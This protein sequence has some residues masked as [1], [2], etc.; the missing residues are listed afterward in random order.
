MLRIAVSTYLIATAGFLSTNLLEVHADGPVP[1]TNGSIDFVGQ[2]LPL[3]ETH[4]LS[5]HGKNKQESGLRLD[6]R[7]K[8]MLGGDRWRSRLA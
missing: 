7:D 3:F 8:A 1:S 4:C 6:Q 5:C 2:V